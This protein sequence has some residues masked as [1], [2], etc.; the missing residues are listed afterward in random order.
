[1]ITEKRIMTDSRK[2]PRFLIVLFAAIAGMPGPLLSAPPGY[3]EVKRVLPEIWK[4]RYPI[5]IQTFEPN[6]SK[7]GVLRVVSGGKY[8]YYYEFS[9]LL[10]LM[11]R[12]SDSDRMIKIG[13]RSVRFYVRYRS[14]LKDPYDVSFARLDLLPGGS[15]RWIRL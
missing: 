5:S 2:L 4:D 11:T 10:P 9:A 13:E 15:R 1:M 8:V 12:D 6:P 14:W 3:S 7:R